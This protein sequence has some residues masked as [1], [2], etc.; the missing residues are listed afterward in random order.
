MNLHSFI[1]IKKGDKYSTL[2]FAFQFIKKITLGTW[3]FLF[4]SKREILQKIYYWNQ[5]NYLF[6]LSFKHFKK[7]KIFN[8]NSKYCKFLYVY[9]TVILDFKFCVSFP[10]FTNNENQ[11]TKTK[12][13]KNNG[14]KF[15]SGSCLISDN[16]FS[17]FFGLIF[18][19]SVLANLHKTTCKK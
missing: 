8:Q 18:F 14:F 6:F 15:Q 9:W 10:S 16:C 19:Y 7:F 11:N 4:T 5:T 2:N 12:Q 13:M 3:I 1:Y 17:L